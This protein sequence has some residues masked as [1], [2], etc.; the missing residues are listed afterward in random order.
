MDEEDVGFGF[1]D[2]DGWGILHD[3][4]VPGADPQMY[5]MGP[6]PSRGIADVLFTRMTCSCTKRVIPIRFPPGISMML[7]VPDLTEDHTHEPIH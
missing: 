5:V 7:S 6:F 1:T 2:E 3:N 4:P